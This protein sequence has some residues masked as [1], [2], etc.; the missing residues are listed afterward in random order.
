MGQSC[1]ELPGTEQA[2]KKGKVGEQGN[3]CLPPTPTPRVAGFTGWQEGSGYCEATAEAS[4][5][6]ESLPGGPPR[7]AREAEINGI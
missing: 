6:G 3:R 1:E 5:E 7:R 4:G 2:L